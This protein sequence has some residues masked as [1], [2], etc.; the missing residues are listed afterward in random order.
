MTNAFNEFYLKRLIFGIIYA[1]VLSGWTTH[2][3]I[4]KNKKTFVNF[5]RLPNIKRKIR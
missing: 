2:S 5:F 3:K 1:L 4:V